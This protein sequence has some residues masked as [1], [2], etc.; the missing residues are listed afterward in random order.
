[1]DLRNL[2]LVMRSSR[3]QVALIRAV[4]LYAAAQEE[5]AARYKNSAARSLQLAQN[6]EQALS[7]IVHRMQVW[8]S[9]L[10]NVHGLTRGPGFAMLLEMIQQHEQRGRVLQQQRNGTQG[11]S[12]VDSRGYSVVLKATQWYSRPLSGTQ[13]HSV[14]LKVTQR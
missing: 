4:Q 11:H 5:L 14:V 2:S 9:T 6:H 3:R 10:A 12:E 7:L 1:M 8:E 13:G